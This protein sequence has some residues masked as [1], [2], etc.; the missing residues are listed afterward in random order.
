MLLYITHVFSSMVNRQNVWTPH[1]ASQETTLLLSLMQLSLKWIWNIFRGATILILIK[2]V[3]NAAWCGIFVLKYILSRWIFNWFVIN[4]V[5]FSSFCGMWFAYFWFFVNCHVIR[6]FTR[7]YQLINLPISL[8]HFWGKQRAFMFHIFNNIL[9]LW[10]LMKYYKHF[11]TCLW[12][13]TISFDPQKIVWNC[14]CRWEAYTAHTL[15][16][17]G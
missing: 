7:C 6:K 14:Y 12:N 9:L 8:I 1:F 17:V 10:L 13:N 4:S 5:G 15:R 2:S 3:G 11:I 16:Q